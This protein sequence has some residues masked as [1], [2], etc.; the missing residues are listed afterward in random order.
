[1]VLVVHEYE[2]K[3][4]CGSWWINNLVRCNHSSVFKG[5]RLAIGK[6]FVVKFWNKPLDLF[7]LFILKG[8]SELNRVANVRVT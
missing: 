4:L 7:G 1:M 3:T 6:E 2:G 8:A 5:Y